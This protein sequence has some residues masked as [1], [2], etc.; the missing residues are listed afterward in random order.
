MKKVVVLGAGYAGLHFI[1]KFQK[2]V[3]PAAV[4]IILVDQNDYHYQTTE[5][6]QVAVGKTKPEQISYPIRDI[7]NSE[8]TTFVQ[9]RVLK[10]DPENKRV[11]LQKHAPIDYDYCILSLGFASETYG[12]PGAQQNTLPLTNVKDA[13]A[14]LAHFQKVADHYRKFHDP[15]DLQILICGMGYTGIELAGEINDIK[16]QLAKM[17]GCESKDIKITLINSLTRLLQQFDPKVAHYGVHTLTHLGIKIIP[18]AT[19]KQIFPGV[20]NYV[21]TNDQTGQRHQLKGHTILWTTGVRG[22]QVIDDSGFANHHGRIKVT[23]HLTVPGHDELYSL[24]DVASVINPERAGEKY[25][26]PSAQIALSMASFAARD[27]AGRLNGRPQKA[28]YKYC[29]LGTVVSI[30]NTHAFGRAL[31]V[32]VTGRS[33]SVMKKLI[34]D[35][36]LYQV[37]GVGK[38]MKLGQFDLYH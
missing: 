11:L 10:I 33:A 36:S 38:M 16:P 8:M 12:I 32:N 21:H 3:D 5:I 27:L 20:V 26:S 15:Q 22:S 13:L 30:G 37:G 25:Y 9:D 7:L 4:Q 1:E 24:G 19:I 23:K 17:A 6:H 18:G 2:R 31:G 34:A 29:W 14:I 35:K 28:D